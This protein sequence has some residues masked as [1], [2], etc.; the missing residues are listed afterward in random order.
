MRAILQN[1]GWIHI[2]YMTP[3]LCEA[4]DMYAEFPW[5][6]TIFCFVISYSFLMIIYPDGLVQE[7]SD[8]VANARELL[9]SCTK[10]SIFMCWYEINVY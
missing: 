6:D 2:C 4:C 3:D 5:K 9:Q 10:P 7:C 8:S 1:D